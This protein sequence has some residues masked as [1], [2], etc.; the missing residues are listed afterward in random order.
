M[1]SLTN[2][3][4]S[5]SSLRRMSKIDEAQEILAALGLPVEQQN[6]ISAYT[7]LALCDIKPYDKWANGK[8]QS[9]TVTKGIM[10]FVA[11]EHRR[12]YAPNTRET[13]RRRVLHQFVQARIVDY[14]PDDPTLPV[15]SP[16]AHYAITET[17]LQV[18]RTYGTANWK[19]AV[20]RFKSAFGDLSERYRNVRE[21][22]LIPIKLTNGEEIKLSPGEHN[23]VEM[24]IVTEFAPRFAKGSELV[25][26]GDTANKDLYVNKDVLKELGIPFDVH[27][28][29]PDVVLYDR[30]RDW[31]FLIEAVTSHGPVSPTRIIQLEAVLKDCK[32]GKIYVTAFP[33]FAEFKKHT[34]SIAWE[35]EIWIVEHPE[36]MIHFNGDK[37]LGPRMP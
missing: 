17:A 5:T 21:Q 29:L 6:D 25:Y 1:K 2:T 19:K 20:K 28:K 9:L 31:L 13:F 36:H 14:N 15:N 24:A 33:D 4:N 23:L 11:R 8:R 7:L 32:A 37:F 35:T 10:Q 16:L 30:K 34:A 18:I 12:E 3:S 27:G 26:L 22:T